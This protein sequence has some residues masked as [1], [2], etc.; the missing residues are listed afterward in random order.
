MYCLCYRRGQAHHFQSQISAYQVN[1]KKFSILVRSE[2]S[3]FKSVIRNRPFEFH[4]KSEFCSNNLRYDFVLPNWILYKIWNYFFHCLKQI[5]QYFHLLIV[6][7]EN[8]VLLWTELEA[9]KILQS[10]CQFSLSS[11]GNS[12][13]NCS[14]NGS[15]ANLD[16]NRMKSFAQADL[17][18]WIFLMINAP[19]LFPWYFSFLRLAWN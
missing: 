1:F 13:V 14:Q 11:S 2:H 5:S 17:L 10:R 8:F 18:E 12:L 6:S 7:F 9:H 15:L 16:R 3:Q 4:L 19:N